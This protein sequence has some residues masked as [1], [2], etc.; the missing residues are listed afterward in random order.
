MTKN[1]KPSM[2]DDY[3]WFTTESNGKTRRY[4]N[5]VAIHHKRLMHYHPKMDL[6]DILVFEKC[7]V[8]QRSFFPRRFYYTAEK[9]K[10]ELRIGRNRFE[11]GMDKMIELGI[12]E[13]SKASKGV[14]LFHKVK[15]EGIVNNL[16]ILYNLPDE[17]KNRSF[18]VDKLTNYF[19]HYL[20]NW[21]FEEDLPD[22]MFDDVSLAENNK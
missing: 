16:H 22:Y 1:S 10:T 15:L 19:K 17:P 8:L 3:F 6:E 13:R 7:L 4:F 18:L 21:K 11:K 2:F 20:S 5:P 12:I 9:F 14:K